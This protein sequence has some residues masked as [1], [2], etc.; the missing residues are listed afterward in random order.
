MA[1]SVF[2]LTWVVYLSYI[3]LAYYTPQ[4]LMTAVI[5]VLVLISTVSYLL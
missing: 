2:L 1:L 4:D 3:S 5:T